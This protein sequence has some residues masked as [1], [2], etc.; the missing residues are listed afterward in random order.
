LNSIVAGNHVGT[1]EAGTAAAGNRG[2]G[3]RIDNGAQFN[4]IGAMPKPET[5]E[6]DAALQRNL[7]SGNYGHGVHVRGLDAFH[8][9]FDLDPFAYPA[10]AALPLGV[11]EFN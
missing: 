3:V 11:G 8:I 5:D 7:I 4:L 2:D 9:E 1:N 6:N 10:D